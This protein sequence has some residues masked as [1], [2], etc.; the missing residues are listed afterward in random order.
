MSTCSGSRNAPGCGAEIV[1]CITDKNRKAI[2]LDPE[3]HPDGVWW[4][5]RLEG[6]DK[7]VHRLTRDELAQPAGTKARYKS[8]WETC[9]HAKEHHKK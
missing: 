8:H 9:P 5:V 7:I 4:K 3:P 1:W 6:Q 2:P